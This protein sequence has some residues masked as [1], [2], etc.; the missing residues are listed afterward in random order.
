MNFNKYALMLMGAGFL[1]GGCS[2]KQQSP[3]TG[4]RYNDKNNGGF[5]VFRKT[6]PA[7]GPGLVAI[8]G[9]TFVQGGSA[10]EDVNYEY[11]NIR[12]RASIST[13]Y[14]DD[15]E[16]SNTDWREYL[17]WLQTNFPDDRELYYNAIPDTLVWRRP[18]SHNDPYVDNYLRGAPFQDYPV[19]GVSWTQANDYCDWRTQR[20]NENI[21]RTQ[22][23]L[24]DWKTRAASQRGK[25]G[26]GANGAAAAPA[27]VATAGGTNGATATPTDPKQAFNTDMYLNGQYKGPGIDGKKMINDMN[28][29]KDTNGSGKVKRPVRK[30]DGILRSGYR[31]PTEAEWEYAALGLAGNTQFENIEEGKIYPWNGMGVRSPKSKTR[32]LML[33]NY[34]RGAGDNA[35]VGG[36]LN[37]KA[38]ITAPVRSYEPN[39]FGL[40][41]M[42]GNVNEWTSDTYRQTS[43]E[44][45]D[46]F[47]PFR[48]NQFTNKQYSDPAKGLYAKDNYGKPVLVPATS[49]K[50]QTW[51]EMI[52]GEQAGSGA[53]NAAGTNTT[54]AAK[55]AIAGKPYSADQRGYADTVNTVLYG[56]TT[57]VN[58][59][60]KVYKGGSWNDRA[61][62]LNP[63]T[64]R[65]MDQD[66]S[67]A[68]VGFRC[69][70]NYEGPPE[71]NPG[72]KSQF[73]VKKAK[74]FNAAKR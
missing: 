21:L 35:G 18:L 39:D 43:F 24:V 16:V 27:A 40:Y 22:G 59:R 3:K 20:M 51:A 8:E 68:E 73:S 62:W 61:Y 53:N 12:K 54:P 65:F 74:P 11:N 36:S 25:G 48:G 10:G 64:R 37:D 38:D 57:L 66:E 46:D 6:H 2:P 45:T 33:A 14:M 42:A 72:G 47:N 70:M 17:Y 63:A 4:M 9:G 34:K 13:F 19:V 44:E 23:Q 1:L 32:G 56:N 7:P 28:P 41:N 69:A 5:Q 26:T 29:L 50:K 15:T 30:E 58:D 67:S 31:L 49:Y 60:S 71:I 52:A 55:N